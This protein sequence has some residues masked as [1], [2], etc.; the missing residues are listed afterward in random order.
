MSTKCPICDCELMPDPNSEDLVCPT[1]ARSW[2]YLEYQGEQQLASRRRKVSLKKWPPSQ[3]D[4][5][6]DIIEPQE[7]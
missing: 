7:K 6:S 2:Y 4:N 5:L 3:G 1:C